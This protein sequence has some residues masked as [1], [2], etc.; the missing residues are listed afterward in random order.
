MLIEPGVVIVIVTLMLA[1]WS[2]LLVKALIS[3]QKH[4]VVKGVKLEFCHLNKGLIKVAF[5]PRFR[6]HP[7]V[8]QKGA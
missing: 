3:W 2:A 8:A 7:P 5:H 4:L 6:H 1:V